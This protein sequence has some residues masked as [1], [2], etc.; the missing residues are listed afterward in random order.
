MIVHH[1]RCRRK[2]N[3]RQVAKMAAPAKLQ[4]HRWVVTMGM[5]QTRRLAFQLPVHDDEVDE[6][7]QRYYC[8]EIWMRRL[9][10]ML[11]C[12]T[13]DEPEILMRSLA[14]RDV[15]LSLHL[16]GRCIRRGVSLLVSD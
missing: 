3:V 8:E 9:A 13:L 11:W 6:E 4:M 10:R 2:N 7:D 16:R 14:R 5:T 1:L 12:Q 15:V